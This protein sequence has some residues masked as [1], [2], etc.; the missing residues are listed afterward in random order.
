MEP[1]ESRGTHEAWL[2]Q[3]MHHV[4]HCC[5]LHVDDDPNDAFLLRY[6]LTKVH[7]VF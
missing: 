7:E 2:D 1:A 5:I 3:R 4:S 6:A